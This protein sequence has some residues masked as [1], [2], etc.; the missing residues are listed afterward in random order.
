M[1]NMQNNRQKKW[2]PIDNTEQIMYLKEDIQL[3]RMELLNI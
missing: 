1:H 3:I 2:V